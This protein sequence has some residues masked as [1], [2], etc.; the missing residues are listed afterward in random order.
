[1]SGLLSTGGGVGGM[2]GGLG[3]PASLQEVLEAAGRLVDQHSAADAQ[4]THDLT[5]LLNLQNYSGWT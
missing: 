3:G 4:A 5:S 1:M 2:M